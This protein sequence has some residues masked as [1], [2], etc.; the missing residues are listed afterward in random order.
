MHQITRALAPLATSPRAAGTKG[1]CLPPRG[2]IKWNRRQD[3]ALA[4]AVAATGPPTQPDG[5]PVSADPGG[6]NVDDPDGTRS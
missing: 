6:I 5:E 1:P 3:T 4:S 2:V